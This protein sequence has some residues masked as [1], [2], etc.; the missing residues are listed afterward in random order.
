MSALANLIIAVAMLLAG[1]TPATYQSWDATLLDILPNTQLTIEQV[2]AMTAT[3]VLEYYGQ[4]G[5]FTPEMLERLNE[6]QASGAEVDGA[7]AT[8]GTKTEAELALEALESANSPEFVFVL[9]TAEGE[10]P[11]ATL[12]NGQMPAVGSSEETNLPEA[13]IS[14]LDGMVSFTGFPEAAETVRWGYDLGR[15]INDCGVA[16]L[17][18]LICNPGVLSFDHANGSD[19]LNPSAVWSGGANVDNT[20][21]T[22]VEQFLMPGNGYMKTNWPGGWIRFDGYE[23]YM[24]PTDNVSFMFVGRGTYPEEGGGQTPVEYE[25]T[26]E[27]RGSAKIMRYPIEDPTASGFYSWTHFNDDVLHQL[28]GD[29]CDY[30]GCGTVII[31]ATDKNRGNIT[32]VK[33][34]A[35]GGYEL[36]YSNSRSE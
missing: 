33:Y 6:I 32:V 14:L 25:V 20:M 21:S 15:D 36:V 2:E 31:V 17:A 26:E 29:N 5:Y 9:P 7:Q 34:T 35:A 24:E 10:M 11:A 27:Y 4:T 12:E 3:D 23:I 30:D 13:D 19:E 18:W 16:S 1:F 28:S 8:E 22:L